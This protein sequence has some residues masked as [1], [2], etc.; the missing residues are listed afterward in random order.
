VAGVA[1]GLLDHV[2]DD[3]AQVGE[4]VVRV[5]VVAAGRR[6]Q[7]RAGQY[8]IGARTLGAVEVEDAGALRLQERQRRVLLASPIGRPS[9]VVRQQ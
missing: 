5:G 4:L 3:P 1:G 8:G 7:R 2:Q 9:P 6:R